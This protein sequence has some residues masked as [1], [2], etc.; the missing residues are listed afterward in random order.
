MTNESIL[1]LA[2]QRKFADVVHRVKKNPTRN[3]WY[4]ND[5]DDYGATLAFLAAWLQSQNVLYDQNQDSKAIEAFECLLE[6]HKKNPFSLN[7]KQGPVAGDFITTE[8]LAPIHFILRS[9]FAEYLL[10]KLIKVGA[11]LD[12]KNNNGRIPIEEAVFQKK[13]A[14]V[15][16][17]AEKQ[18]LS[19]SVFNSLLDFQKYGH[20]LFH[21]VKNS[22]TAEAQ[23]AAIALLDANAP[24][25]DDL[26]KCGKSLLELAIDAGKTDIALK[27]IEKG[28]SLS[29]KNK[30]QQTPVE[31]AAIH[32]KWEIVK[33]IANTKKT[34]S[35]LWNDDIC[36]Y[37]KAAALAIKANQ[38]DTAKLLI[39]QGT[40]LSQKL[41]DN[42]SLMDL[43]ALYKNVTLVDYLLEGFSDP[44]KNRPVSQ[45]H[46]Q[47][48]MASAMDKLAESDFDQNNPE[49]LAY[50]QRIADFI[51]SQTDL[52]VHDNSQAANYRNALLFFLLAERTNDATPH[53]IHTCYSHLF[54]IDKK[55]YDFWTLKTTNKKDLLSFSLKEIEENSVFKVGFFEGNP[56]KNNINDLIEQLKPLA[57]KSPRVA[58]EIFRLYYFQ[59]NLPKAFKYLTIA[60]DPLVKNPGL[61]DKAGHDALDLL[62][63]LA[64]S[65]KKAMPFF[66][67]IFQAIHQYVITPSIET[68]QKLA[69]LLKNPNNSVVIGYLERIANSDNH[70]SKQSQKAVEILSQYY[71]EKQDYQKSAYWA[72]HFKPIGILEDYQI[73]LLKNDKIIKHLSVDDIKEILDKNKQEENFT[74]EVIEAIL[75]G[76]ITHEAFGSIYDP[77]IGTVVFYPNRRLLEVFV[78]TDEK[79]YS[80]LSF[81]LI[82]EK[83][84]RRWDD[85][86]EGQ[87]SKLLLYLITTHPGKLIRSGY[88]NDHIKNS[89]EYLEIKNNNTALTQEFYANAVK[90]LLF[91]PEGYKELGRW[92]AAFGDACITEIM[93]RL[94]LNYTPSHIIDYAKNPREHHTQKILLILYGYILRYPD[95]PDLKTLKDSFQCPYTHLS[96]LYCLFNLIDENKNIL[97]DNKDAWKKVLR[98]Y[99][100]DILN[101]HT[102]E[103]THTAKLE[104]EYANAIQNPVF[105]RNRNG[106]L[107]AIGL[108][109]DTVKT[110]KQKQKEG[111]HY[112]F[113]RQSGNTLLD[114]IN[115]KQQNSLI[116]HI[117][118]KYSS[119]YWKQ[120]SSLESTE[121]YNNLTNIN[122]PMAN[123]L[124]ALKNYM[125]NEKNQ[126]K[127]LHKIIEQEYIQFLSQAKDED[128]E[129]FNTTPQSTADV[130]EL[131][132]CT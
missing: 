12:V 67:Q 93:A 41:S 70:Y 13:W 6:S 28:A 18:K 113:N 68:V 79:L 47:Q 119:R 73:D 62:N 116:Q 98:S 110:I 85:L 95:K 1:T 130:S 91:Q 7:M 27:L 59:E 75:S 64:Q 2:Q 56:I 81:D 84:A 103:I 31:Y 129:D 124:N 11:D 4:K 131:K 71:L 76:Y 100:F 106:F 8:A 14:C 20:A 109:T 115:E 52:D 65:H 24:L 60:S 126:E 112:F 94:K 97:P 99:A 36:H 19:L 88:F 132:R 104:Q 48:L 5:I 108:E 127:T 49:H 86:P 17:I 37:T 44:T 78:L 118:E 51:F 102:Q 10:G 38:A 89:S 50:H 92:E 120:H 117:T 45:K 96:D 101:S 30:A 15:R 111:L 121:L 82:L 66:A 26:D 34:K 54:G 39:E 114:R 32:N 42:N 63:Q 43:I 25:I 61:Q 105:A 72:F 22:Q 83:L 3:T 87:I 128:F 58:L 122:S 53:L 21:A 123:K 55:Q 46:L 9:P 23:K 57:A 40:D 16:I 125:S 29:A 80:K 35:S 107:N 74:G 77:K 33:A 90:D 69:E